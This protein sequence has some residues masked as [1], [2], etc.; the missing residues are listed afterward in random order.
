MAQ[1]K[2]SPVF[3]TITNTNKTISGAR[4][5]TI[6]ASGGEVEIKTTATNSFNLPIGQSITIEA[7]NEGGLADITITS[8]SASIDAIVVWMN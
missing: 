5:I 4:T 7:T 6:L 8:A 1:F 3:E 2:Q